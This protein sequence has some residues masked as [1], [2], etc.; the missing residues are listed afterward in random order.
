[1][2]HLDTSFLIH[3]L[4]AGSAQEKALVAWL[5]G[6]E[7]L[8]ISA[9]AWAEF[10]CGP[11][12]P[13]AASRALDL[14]G[15]PVPLDQATAER[16]AELFNLGGRRRGSLADCLIAAAAMEAGA[17]LATENAADF[18]RFVPAGLTLAA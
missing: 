18:R 3:A 2:I 9:F 7:E 10:L 11:V 15:A 6:T 12:S 5:A 13:S 16:A 1:V 4:R 14:L 17:S 8:G